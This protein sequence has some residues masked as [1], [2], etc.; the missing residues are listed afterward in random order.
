MVCRRFFEDN[1]SDHKIVE[2]KKEVCMDRE[3]RGSTL[4]AQGDV[5]D[6]ADT[7]SP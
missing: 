1:K 4:K 7:K 3:M 5:D 6:N 2:E